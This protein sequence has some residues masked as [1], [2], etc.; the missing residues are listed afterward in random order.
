MHSLRVTSVAQLAVPWVADLLRQTA[1]ESGI[2]N[3]S[4][5]TLVSSA[6][7]GTQAEEIMGDPR[8]TAPLATSKSSQDL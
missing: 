3:F 6:P 8:F 2:G 1:D 4:R 7:L 5:V